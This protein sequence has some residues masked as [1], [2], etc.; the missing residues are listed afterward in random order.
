MS[1]SHVIFTIP[2][3]KVKRFSRCDLDTVRA[4]ETDFARNS[5]IR[6]KRGLALVDPIYSYFLCTGVKG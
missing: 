2:H 5:G 4:K 3:L 6:E 1:T